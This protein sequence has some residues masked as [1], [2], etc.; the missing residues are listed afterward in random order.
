[1]TR[2]DIGPGLAAAHPLQHLSAG[3]LRHEGGRAIQRKGHAGLIHPALVTIGRFAGQPQ[4]A[5][6]TANNLR[7]EQG[8]LNEHAP[9]F[10]G[11]FRRQPPHD[12]GQG[13]GTLGV[14]D[15]PVAGRQNA[16]LTIQGDEFFPLFRA[17]H[18]DAAAGQPVAIKG[19]AE[20]GPSSMRI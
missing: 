18:D 12:P 19:S 13:H 17:A 4:T 6:S 14:A 8:A 5:G 2:S 11:N 1:M 20:A 7:L 10:I 16:F 9:C 15:Q 3:K